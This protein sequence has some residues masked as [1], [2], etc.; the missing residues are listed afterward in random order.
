MGWNLLFVDTILVM[1]YNQHTSIQNCVDL[2]DVHLNTVTR[3]CPYFG[4]AYGVGLLP[5]T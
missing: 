2:C 3:T 1:I 5:Y 4:E